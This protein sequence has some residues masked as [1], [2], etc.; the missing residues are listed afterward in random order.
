MAAFERLDWGRLDVFAILVGDGI[1]TIA[2]SF[3]MHAIEWLRNASYEIVVL[4]FKGGIGVVVSELG[5][6]FRWEQQFGYALQADDR[7]LARL[8]DG[9]GYSI[10][11]GGGLVLELRNF[12]AAFAEDREWS[13]GFLRVLSKHSLR[14]LALGQRFFGLAHVKDGES[15]IV[16]CSLGEKSVPYPYPFP[17]G[18]GDV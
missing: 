11:A 2:S 12:E 14:H 7:N 16:G 3:S 18:R 10:P 4:D 17:Q 8:G 1:A 9:F 13:E 15:P 5:K 6:T